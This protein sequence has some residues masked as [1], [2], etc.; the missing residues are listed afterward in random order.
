MAKLFDKILCPID[1]DEN[2][3]AALDL[4]CELAGPDST[5]VLLHSVDVP[6]VAQAG[7]ATEP[8]PVTEE[9]AKS[10]LRALAD[11]RLEGK[12]GYELLTDVGDPARAILAAA[13]RLGVASIVMATHGRKVLGRL[14]LGSVAARVVR[15]AT[16]PVL[17]IRPEEEKT[18]GED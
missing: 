16:C 1:F 6:V 8:Y 12:V 2:S 11:E 7:V 5:I 3:I 9:D 15:E 18:S 13:E 14:M 17:T 4:A 10:N